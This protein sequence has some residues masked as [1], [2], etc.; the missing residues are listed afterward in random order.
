MYKGV[1]IS[2]SP[3]VTDFH[4]LA[5]D[6]LGNLCVKELLH[7]SICPVTNCIYELKSNWKMSTIPVT[8]FVAPLRQTMPAKY[9]CPL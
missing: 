9:F 8:C 6:L 5:A 3:S 2:I 1:N 7:I 4:V